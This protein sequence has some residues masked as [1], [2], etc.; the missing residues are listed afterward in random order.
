MS[1]EVFKEIMTENFPKIMKDIKSSRVSENTKQGKDSSTHL[2]KQPKQKQQQKT[3]P[4]YLILKLLQTKDRGEIS[5][6]EKDT[7]YMG[8]QS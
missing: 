2:K 5:K 3:I 4:R 1:E 6:A 8:E 7:S